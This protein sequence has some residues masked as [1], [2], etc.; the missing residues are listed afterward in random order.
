MELLTILSFEPE[1]SDEG[2]IYQDLTIRKIQTDMS[3]AILNS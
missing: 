1:E 2:E 3:L